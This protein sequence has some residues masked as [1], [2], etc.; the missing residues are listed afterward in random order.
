MLEDTQHVPSVEIGS[1]HPSWSLAV[2]LTIALKLPLQP[3]HASHS[4][5]L[6]EGI[7]TE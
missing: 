1:S 4:K 3:R 6:P 2:E 5:L 7:R